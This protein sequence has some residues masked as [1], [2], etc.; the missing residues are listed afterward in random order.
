MKTVYTNC[1]CS[2][3]EK[4][5]VNKI[6]QHCDILENDVLEFV[7]EGNTINFYLRSEND[8]D[9]YVITGKIKVTI[10]IKVE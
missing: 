3:I 9:D 10:T 4:Q 7:K 1:S 5:V 6:E 8:L 2:E